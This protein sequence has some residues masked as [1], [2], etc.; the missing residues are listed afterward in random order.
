MLP[1]SQNLYGGPLLSAV[2]LRRSRS[3]KGRRR[4][5]SGERRDSTSLHHRD[6]HRRP[7]SFR[8]PVRI[9]D[10]WD[11]D[12][13]AITFLEE[14][15]PPPSGVRETERD[16]SRSRARSRSRTRIIHPAAQPVAADEAS[17]GP[18]AHFGMHGSSL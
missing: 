4:R 12:S 6:E 2:G 8:S 10:G 18:L 1:P 17:P 15:T 13:P 11:E 9:R 3:P 16:R 5:W 14:A 7:I